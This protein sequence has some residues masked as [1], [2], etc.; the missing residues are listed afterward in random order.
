MVIGKT[1]ANLKADVML[2]NNAKT[3][4]QPQVT[5]VRPL[6]HLFWTLS[7]VCPGFESQGGS[8]HLHASLP[9]CNRI[10]NSTSSMTLTDLL[11]NQHG[12]QAILIHV[13]V[14]NHW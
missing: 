3:G 8:P 4:S 2:A 5:F 12:N 10:L 6:I 13:L 1:S 9:V 11:G 14:N 7:I